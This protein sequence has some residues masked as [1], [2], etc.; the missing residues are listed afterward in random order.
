M[1]TMG[2]QIGIVC[3]QAGFRTIMVDINE[4][5]AQVGLQNIR[6]FLNNRQQKGKLD[7]NSVDKTLSLISS[8]V[9]IGEALSAADLVIE[10]VFEDIEAKKQV[11]KTMDS[12]APKQAILASNTSTLWITE[13]AAVHKSSRE[14]HRHAFL[15][16]R[17]A[18]S[19]CGSG[20]RVRD[21]G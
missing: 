13:I 1:G 11:F 8:G 19:T 10:A 4:D 15:D 6:T 3:A 18:D 21:I 9:D 2:S 5:R 20:S 16:S 7:K 14:V 17:R 12:K